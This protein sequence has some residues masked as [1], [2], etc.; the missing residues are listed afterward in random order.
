[1]FSDFNG[2]KEAKH[3]SKKKRIIIGIIVAVLLIGI[4][5]GVFLFKVLRK[6]NTPDK[7]VKDR[8]DLQ[9]MLLEP[10]PYSRP[11]IPLVKVNGIV[12]HYT[13]NPGA[14]AKQNRDYFNGLKDSKKTKASSHFIVGLDGEIVQCIP[15]KEISYASN[16]RNKDTISIECCIEDNTG[17]FNKKTYDSVVELTAWLV[18]RYNL[19]CDDIIRHYDVTGKLCPKYYVQ[20]PSAWKQFKKDVQDYID[21]HGVKNTK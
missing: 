6:K 13:A 12:I 15:C 17:K 11:Q 8:P 20:H 3:N 1:M 2:E 5:L 21:K 4:V 10:N 7:K 19:S 9:V 14:T 16:S 18:G